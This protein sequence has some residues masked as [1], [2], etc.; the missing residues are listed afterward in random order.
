VTQTVLA[1]VFS[2]AAGL[3]YATALPEGLST[4]RDLRGVYRAAFCGRADIAADV[5]GRTLLS[6]D[7]E[8]PAA[9]PRPANPARYRLLFIPGFLASCFPGIHSFADIVEVARAQ[10]F[11]ADVLAVG[12]RNGVIAN[13]RLVAE[14]I[15]RLPDDGRRI[16]L[17]GHSKGAAEALE[18]LIQ[19][20]DLAR[21]VAGVL[22]LA[23]ALQGSPLA[24]NLHNAYDVTLGAL[25]FTSC[26]RGEG[27]PVVDLMLTSRR[28]WW[29]SVAPQLRTPVYSLVTLPDLDRLSPGL[30]TPYFLLS[31]YSR[32]NDGMLLAR[33]QV[34]PGGN[35][36]GVVNADHLTIGIPYPGNAWVFIF[37]AVSFPRPQMVLAAVDVIASR[38]P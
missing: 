3:A 33:D 13:A 14:Q 10:G 20:P 11:A 6:F 12:G 25:P 7:G 2:L 22:T 35:L 34:A 23:G 4:E 32:D 24:E 26:D 31:R 30:V 8:S 15:D 18:V 37:A 19:R 38:E 17:V 27:N 28:E 1:L 36:L 9:R 21:N 29:A 5:C 16:V